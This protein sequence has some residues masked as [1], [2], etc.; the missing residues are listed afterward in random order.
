M[1]LD[2]LKIIF[3]SVEK[4]RNLFYSRATSSSSSGSTWWTPYDYFDKT[5]IVG[6][7]AFLLI[8]LFA[9][10]FFKKE[11]EKEKMYNIYGKPGVTISA[12]FQAG[13]SDFSITQGEEQKK[14]NYSDISH[15]ERLGDFA[16][17]WLKKTYSFNNKPIGVP[18]YSTAFTN[19]SR[20]DFIAALNAKNS[21]NSDFYLAT[22]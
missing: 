8:D 1:K 5:G 13:D 10:L 11:N 19:I 22:H 3:A 14:F 15:I 21:T 20:V 2:N 9:N 18:I 4:E 16:I 6:S 7:T 17:I 12:I